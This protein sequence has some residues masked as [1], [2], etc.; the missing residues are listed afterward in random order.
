ML[1]TQTTKKYKYSNNI[2]NKNG[3]LWIIKNKKKK[4][5]KHFIILISILLLTVN[6]IIS[7]NINHCFFY[8]ILLVITKKH[9]KI[10]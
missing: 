5:H 2:N 8:V 10:Y 4:W 7:Y 6:K 9:Q 3:K 1:K